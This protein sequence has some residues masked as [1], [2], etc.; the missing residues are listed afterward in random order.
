MGILYSMNI[1]LAM[2]L[3]YR[4]EYIGLLQLDKQHKIIQNIRNSIDREVCYK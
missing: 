1:M 2:R 3:I 4:H